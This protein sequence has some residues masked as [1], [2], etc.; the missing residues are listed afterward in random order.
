MNKRRVLPILLA[1][2][3]ASLLLGA[4]LLNI[5]SSSPADTIPEPPKQIYGYELVQ[6]FTGEEALNKISSIHGFS[7]RL[8]SITDG[9]IAIYASETD[10]AHIW[11][12]A[13]TSPEEANDLAMLMYNEMSRGDTPYTMP[14]KMV[15][16][17]IEVYWGM[18][19]QM[20]YNFFADENLVIWVSMTG[21][22]EVRTGFIE[23]LIN[24]F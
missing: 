3:A 22:D 7:S 17:G 20:Y 13:V 15:I 1:V 11:A 2:I 8:S 4:Y 21:T 6:L 18:G 12:A 23:E 16:S 9:L 5:R 19:S 14:E 10:I 24:S